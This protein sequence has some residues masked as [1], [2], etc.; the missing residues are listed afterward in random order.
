MVGFDNKLR[1]AYAYIRVSLREENPE[2]QRQAILEW[3][4][5]NGYQVVRF[6]EDIGVSGA[7]KPENRPG[8]SKLLEAVKSDPKPILVYELS[9]LGRSFYETFNAMMMLEEKRAPVIAVS[10][11]ERFLQNLD[12][13]IR[14]L[15][16][17]I[18]AWVAERERELLRQ[19]TREGMRRAKLEGKHIGRPRKPVDIKKA[20]EL[21]RKGM[22]WADIARY[23]GVSYHTLKRRLREAGINQG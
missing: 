3:A 15:I 6:F 18:F 17:A 23:F 21:R 2:N 13:E 20:L 5:E 1:E 10:P 8:F 22:S 4:G 16:I 14:K 12:P 7:V 11:K 19:R 9:R